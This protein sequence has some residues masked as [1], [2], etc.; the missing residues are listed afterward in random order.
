MNNFIFF[1]ITFCLLSGISINAGAQKHKTQ[2]GKSDAF[3]RFIE[4]IEIR[5]DGNKAGNFKDNLL[6]I[7]VKHRSAGSTS[8]E[9][10]SA[11]HF[12]YAQ[13]LNC[14]VEYIKND[15][16]YNFIDAWW[17]TRYRFGG[18]S[19]TGIDCSSFT[20]LLMNDVFGLK[21]PR[22]AR[23][24]FNEC[25]KL[26]K[27]DLNEGDLVFFNTRGGISHVG[28]YI[29]LNYFVHAS[30]N[31]GVTISSLEDQYYNSRFVA[32]GRLDQNK[33]VVKKFN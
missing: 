14:D 18:S 7:P 4:N 16:L 28:V 17:E 33:D 6:D 2:A 12:K 13:L 19:K 5:P 26:E 1:S 25:T 15:C 9:S 30:T 23:D 21:L 3:P 20:G 29:G 24:Q 31:N 10:S 22:T 11:L 32:G 8:I 27:C